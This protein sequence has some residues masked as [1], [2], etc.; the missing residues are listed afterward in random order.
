[1]IYHV[2]MLYESMNDNKLRSGPL[3]HLSILILFCSVLPRL[4]ACARSI[5]I[6]FS[7]DQPFGSS[8]LKKPV[9]P[10]TASHYSSPAT[11]NSHPGTTPAHSP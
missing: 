7:R 8:P 9:S 6:T 10:C 2:Y 11:A 4:R 1:M 5:P 3:A